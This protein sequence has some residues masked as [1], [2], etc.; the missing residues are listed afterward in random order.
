[1]KKMYFIIIYV[2]LLSIG[3]INSAN[4]SITKL[5]AYNIVISGIDSTT[6]DS[7]EIF[8]SKQ[9][10][11]ANTVIEIGDKSIESPDY[12]SWMFFINK[13]PLSNWGH[14]CNY[15]FI[16]SN[17]G[18]VD[19]IESNFYPTKPSLADMDKIKSSVVTFDESVFVKPMARPQLLQ[20]KAT[21]D[22]NKYAV[23]ISGGGNPSVNYPRY[24]N[25]CSS[26]YQTLLYTYNYDPA[27]ITVIMSDGTSSNID[28]S[29]GDSSPLDLDGNG[30]NDIQFAATSNNIKTTFSNLASR[31][32]SNDYLFIF[33]IDHG[34]YDSSG[35]SSLTLWNDENLY[36]STFAPWV[37][38]INAKAI[39]IVMGQ[40]FSGGF[41]SYFKNNP[42]VSI[43]TAS[44]KD[45]PSSSMSDGRYDEFVYYWTEAVT[46][47]ASSGYMV[48]D[49]NQDAF[50]TAHE[51]YDYTRTHDKKN[52]DPQHYS[53]DLL[54]H[55]LAL[56][57]M[58]ARTTS[59]TIA[60]ERGE[61]FNYSGMETINWT[62]P[63]NSPVNISIKFPTN[64]VYKWNCSSG[65]PG[66]FYSS[67]ST[68]ASVLANSSSTSPI[69]IT[70]KADGSTLTQTFRL[71]L[72][73]TYS[74]MNDN[75]SILNINLE[76]QETNNLLSK[77]QDSYEIYS[78]NGTKCKSGLLN[79]YNSIDISSLANGMYFVTIHN[80]NS[81]LQ[82]EQFIVNH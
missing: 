25:D 62:I 30:T 79:R 13:Y 33:T 52:E 70:A 17:N 18:E 56:N 58:R 37:N 66:N 21:Y 53:S 60:V 82:K 19:I 63:L 43:S 38:A 77:S 54:S 45:Q 35:N 64:I 2:L 76:N 22:S 36:A 49:V 11:P 47:K 48:G 67:S 6:L 42:K 14:S 29:T 65:N 9:I 78:I 27:H 15:M 39:N 59:G 61:T 71:Y 1:M 4:K 69:V 74:I 24:W 34:N 28:R 80:S 20:T 41:I 55:F 72:K 3:A 44:T 12:G 75:S 32:T 73:N 31:L 26:I 23:I 51:A 8:V 7:T 50:T 10:L 5:E 57:G 81:I 46:K 16:G 68:T 40:C